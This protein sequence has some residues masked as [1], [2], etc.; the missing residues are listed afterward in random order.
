MHSVIFNWI[1]PTQRPIIFIKSGA[2]EKRSLT[3]QKKTN[4]EWFRKDA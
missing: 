1:E 3:V 2:K 4:E